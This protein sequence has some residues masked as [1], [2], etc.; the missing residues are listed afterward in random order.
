MFNL[1]TAVVQSTILSYFLGK[2]REGKESI[3]RFFFVKVAPFGVDI[4]RG[5]STGEDL[6]HRIGIVRCSTSQPCED[7]R[8][9]DGGGLYFYSDCSASSLTVNIRASRQGY[10]PPCSYCATALEHAGE[11]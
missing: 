4:L 3:C 5:G 10:S 6:M 2:G 1:V 11:S 9:S 7:V 8:A